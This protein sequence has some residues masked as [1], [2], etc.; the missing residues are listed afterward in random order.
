MPRWRRRR[1]WRDRHTRARR[2][3]GFR[4][5]HVQCRHRRSYTAVTL[6]PR[7]H[8][9]RR[10]Q[11]ARDYCRTSR[12]GSGRHLSRRPDLDCLRCRIL[13]ADRCCRDCVLG[14]W[15]GSRL[16]SA[17]F[18]SAC[19]RRIRTSPLLI[20]GRY[21]Q[22]HRPCDLDRRRA[23]GLHQHRRSD[24]G[25]GRVRRILRPRPVFRPPHR[26]RCWRQ[27]RG[28]ALRTIGGHAH[29]LLRLYCSCARTCTATRARRARI[30]RCLC[31]RLRSRSLRSRSLCSWRWRL[32]E[33]ICLLSLC[34][35]GGTGHDRRLQNLR[36][37][38]VG[39]GLRR[40]GK[41]GVGRGRR[42]HERGRLR[43]RLHARPSL[44]CIL[45]VVARRMCGVGGA[46]GQQQAAQGRQEQEQEQEEGRRPGTHDDGE[47]GRP[48]A[49]WR[50]DGRRWRRGRRY[51]GG[52]W[53]RWRRWR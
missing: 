31:A 30:R 48:H 3:G 51:W 41:Q 7:S 25:C 13:R 27:H 15:V 9:G 37:G 16:I 47:I 45:S 19:P 21:R 36:D 50:R 52:R 39:L 2:G 38:L 28:W 42:L 24:R 43:A 22:R 46:Q 32:E 11:C 5:R 33:E 18:E 17:A 14:R 49:K 8:Q 1:Q 12:C 6:P 10:R 40:R 20:G 34:T 26:R 53:R 44:H 23:G 35:T 29:G 4:R